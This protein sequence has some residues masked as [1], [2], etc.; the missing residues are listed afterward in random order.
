MLAALRPKMA[1]YR[2]DD[3]DG[4][5]SLAWIMICWGVLDPLARYKMAL[6][7]GMSD[8][9]KFHNAYWPDEV[10]MAD[11][12]PQLILERGEASDLPPALLIYGAEDDVLPKD[13]ADRFADAYRLAG[14]D[15]TVRMYPDEGHL[16][17]TKTP[18]SPAAQDAM[19]A[20]I[21]FSRE[22]SGL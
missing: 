4:D 1:A 17:A 12:N 16:F 6:A 22:R 3:T 15:I 13:T 20:M 19:E 2:I 18:A 14:G 21:R 11:G 7:R 5:G 10:A 8:F 9:I